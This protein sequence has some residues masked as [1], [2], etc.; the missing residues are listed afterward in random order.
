MF[1]VKRALLMS[2]GERYFLLVSNFL[3][4]ALVSRILTPQ[5][6]GVSIIGMA[7]LAM[8]MSLREFSS[9]SFLIQREK[10]SNDDISCAFTVMFVL[11]GIVSAFL[12]LAAPALARF[13]DEPNLVPYFRVIAICQLLDCFF[14]IINAL[15]RREMKFGKVASINIT[16]AVTGSIATIS[17][18]L[19]GFSYM[20]FAYA[21]LIGS[22]LAAGLAVL[23][24]PHL[25]MFRP[26]LRNWRAMV[27]FGGYNGAI[28]MLYRIFEALPLLL[29]GRFISPHAVALFNRTMM[30]G[31]VPDKLVLS[32]AMSVVL[33]AFAAEVREGRDLKLPYLKALSFITALHWPA[34]LLISVLAYPAVEIVLGPQWMEAVPLVQIVTIALLF[35]FSFEIN[36]PVLVAMGAIRD[37]FIRALIVFPASGLIMC[38]AV[39]WGSLEAVVACLLLTMPFQAFVALSFVKRR[40]G[41]NWRDIAASLWK[42]AIIATATALAPLA[43]MLWLGTGLAISPLQGIA[44]AILAASAWAATLILIRH[45]LFD[46]IVRTIPA[47]RKQALHPV[48]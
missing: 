40:L 36:Y 31:A 41:L 10:L 43:A 28:A 5:E 18:A 2:T 7:I 11:T 39:W 17:L 45:P 14:I 44:A 15:L 21:W 34:L 42:S 8:V 20:S 37:L 46:E 33:P 47:F 12:V 38:A 24:R 19:M 16:G 27:S 48:E 26:S 4:A 6:I 32:G 25:W 30:I 1:S 3:T 22:A 35:S 23:L 13:Y 9:S 29:L